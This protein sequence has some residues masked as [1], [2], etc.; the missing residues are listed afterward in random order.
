MRKDPI[1][2][3]LLAEKVAPLFVGEDPDIIGGT[4]ANLLALYIAGH[5][6]DVRDDVL[7]AVVECA[8]DLVPVCEKDIIRQHGGGDPW[9]RGGQS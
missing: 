3:V 2:C 6:P 1:A 7:E 8:R 9:N 5:R 4:L